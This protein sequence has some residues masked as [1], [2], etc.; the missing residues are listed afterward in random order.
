[1][2]LPAARLG[3]MHTC[4]MVDPGPKPHVGG[5]IFIG[6]PTVLIGSQP[7]ARVGDTAACL[8]PPDSIVVGSFSVKIQGQPAARLNDT[9]AHGGVVVA[10][11]ST[12]LIGTA[13]GGSGFSVTMLPDGRVQF[14]KNIYI[15]GDRDFQETVLEDLNTIATTSSSDPLRAPGGRT[16][17][18]NI[19]NGG[20]MVIISEVTGNSGNSCNPGSMTNAQD[21]AVGSGSTVN[22]NTS[23]EPPTA[24]DPTVNRPADV[25]LHHELAHADHV[26]SGTV[27]L[28]PASN[29]NNPHVE[30]ENTI[31]RD[32]LYRDDRGIPNRADHT[33]L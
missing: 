3:D 16:T 28:S 20:H 12:V 26:S 6:A 8:G 33:V 30:E 7:A 19:D 10:G 17:L 25:G 14:G 27:D 22:Y 32:N 18:E 15:N 4:P 29:P 5:P 1:M 21:S 11:M 31:A 13:V 9:T 23:R 2:G 24:A